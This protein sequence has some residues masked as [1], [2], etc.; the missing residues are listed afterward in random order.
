[1]TNPMNWPD[2][3]AA[4]AERRARN[5]RLQELAAGLRAQ[6][7]AFSRSAPGWTVILWGPSEAFFVLDEDQA[8][9][10]L[11]QLKGTS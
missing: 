10:L 1:M 5:E 11:D 3:D 4:I 8:R 7:V 9:A 2:R 6:G